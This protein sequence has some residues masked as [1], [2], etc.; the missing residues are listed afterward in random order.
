MTAKVPF[1]S[2]GILKFGD[3]LTFCS[4]ETL[5]D[6]FCGSEIVKGLVGV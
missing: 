2:F 6:G 4:T 1:H 3:G 5:M